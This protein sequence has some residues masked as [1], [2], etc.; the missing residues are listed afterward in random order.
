MTADLPRAGIW[1]VA[2]VGLLIGVVYA[3]RV[4]IPAG[5]NPSIFLALGEDSPRQTE[6]AEALLG[7]VVLRDALGHDGKFFFAQ[8][9]DPLYIQPEVHAAFLDRPV[10]RGQRMLFPLLAGGLGMFPPQVVVWA[11]LGLNLLA[12][13]FATAVGARLAKLWGASTWL[14]LAVPLNLGLLSEV[15]IGGAGVV[16]MLMSLGAVLALSRQGSSVPTRLTGA[17]ALFCLAALSREVALVFAAGVVVVLWVLHRRVFWSLLVFPALVVGGWRLYLASR[18]T[19]LDPGE[20]N[21]EL[22]P[23]LTGIWDAFNYWLEEPVDL[24]IGLV[25]LVVLMAFTVRALRSRNLLAWGA[26]PTVAL[27]TILSVYVWREPY[28]LARAITPVLSAYPFLLFLPVAKDVSMEVDEQA[29][30]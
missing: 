19:G 11:M 12:L 15:D 14:G 3:L 4:L 16:A 9:N 24:A 13:G 7:Q 25:L 2:G 18:L 23:P 29:F 5:W 22:A 10:Y 6:Y 17:T 27:A 28:D 30:D 8:A 21:R 20:A 26:L 1:K